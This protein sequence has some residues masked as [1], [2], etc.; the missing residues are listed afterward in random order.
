MS[1]PTTTAPPRRLGLILGLLGVFLLVVMMDNTIVNIA[2]RSIQEELGAT[3]SELQWSVDSYIL[4]Y[5][6]LMFPAGI[7]ADRYGRKRVL[8]AGLAVFAIASAF[9]AFATTPDQLILWRAIMGVGGAVVPP[10]TLSIIRDS[11][12]SERQGSAMGIWSAIGGS[13]VAF[14]PIIG[15][16]LLERFWWGSVFLINVP[17]VVIAGAL[18]IWA[19]PESKAAERKRLD[20]PGILLSIAGTA[21]LVFGV[22]RGGETTNWWTWDAA[23]AIAGGIAVLVIFVLIER[24]RSQPTIDVSLFRNRAFVSGTLSMALAF[25]TVTGGTYLLVFYSL[26]VRGDSTLQFGFILLPVAIGSVLAAL[27]ANALTR[28][29][30]PRFTVLL[31]LG[32]LLVAF[33]LLRFLTPDTSLVLIEG[34]L[35]LAG[36]GIGSVM[37]TTTPLVMAVVEP[38]KAGAGAA[39]NNAIRQIGAALGVAIL[40]SI[41]AIQYRS[42]A[43]DAL[44]PWTPP[45]PEQ[46]SE[47]LGATATALDKAA[48]SGDANL[49]HAIPQM[50]AQATD[51]FTASLQTTFTVAAA[52]L[53]AGIVLGTFWLP[54]RRAT[55]TTL[56]E[57]P[58]LSVDAE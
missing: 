12:P 42:G 55:Q 23:G 31:G 24:R 8:L 6:A 11:F 30:G 10:A 54:G 47:S 5:A 28:A 21:L 48:Q 37:G 15:G 41:Y 19:M 50:L 17:I 46:A 40:G 39:A 14:G 38:E 58:G 18:A 9:S 1:N 25:F 16:L 20:I 32:A 4:I 57:A 53:A 34:A 36:I 33:V 56:E 49:L 7:L 26:I 51:S 3:N 44:A 35:L 29:R 45:L 27:S 43:A 2:L 52:V 13:S 22:I